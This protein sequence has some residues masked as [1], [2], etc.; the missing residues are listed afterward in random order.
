[1]ITVFGISI[2]QLLPFFFSFLRCS[3]GC[4]EIRSKVFISLQSLASTSTTLFLSR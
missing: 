1:M 4:L 2:P 3:D